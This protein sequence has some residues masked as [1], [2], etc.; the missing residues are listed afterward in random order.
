MD[1]TQAGRSHRSKRRPLRS[2]LE[3]R[4]GRMQAGRWHRSTGR[5][6]RSILERC[7]DRTQAGRS[8]RSKYRPLRSS[9]AALL[10]LLPQHQPPRQVGQKQLP[11]KNHLLAWAACQAAADLHHH[12]D[13]WQPL[14]ELLPQPF[15]A[16]ATCPVAAGLHRRSHVGHRHEHVLLAQEVFQAAADLRHHLDQ[17]QPLLELVLR[18]LR[19]LAACLLQGLQQHRLV[20]LKFLAQGACQV[21]ADHCHQ[22]THLQHPL[23][24]TVQ[25]LQQTFHP[26]RVGS[27]PLEWRRATPRQA[28]A[29]ALLAHQY[30][31]MQR[32]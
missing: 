1:R 24:Q 21:A 15:L 29:L 11:V 23:K 22:K 4:L 26:R 25:H 31:W 12:L 9:L 32:C 6:R 10:H 14:L 5:L 3:L 18:S 17:R 30:A 13:R 16:R 20:H 7:L 27:P 8:H 28:P 2:N 19:V